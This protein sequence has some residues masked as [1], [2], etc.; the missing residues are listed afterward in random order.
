MNLRTVP[1][2]NG[3]KNRR[4]SQVRP[5]TSNYLVSPAESKIGRFTTKIKTDNASESRE[6]GAHYTDGNR[7]SA[8]L[9]EQ[10]DGWML[11]RWRRRW[12]FP[13]E[14]TGNGSDSKLAPHTERLIR[15]RRSTIEP[16]NWE[17]DIHKYT[18]IGLLYC[19]WAIHMLDSGRMREG[20]GRMKFSVN[21]ISLN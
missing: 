12:P 19:V 11:Q 15:H 14:T 4:I 6:F 1:V 7:A 20:A 21:Y 13:E 2:L 3:L 5:L 17:L 9:R 18:R 10:R 8:C 16:H